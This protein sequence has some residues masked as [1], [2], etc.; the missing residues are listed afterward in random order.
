M[1]ADWFEEWAEGALAA[2]E[3]EQEVEGALRAALVEVA[4]VLAAAAR[5][6]GAGVRRAV[7]D[8]K[9]QRVQKE[10]AVPLRMTS[11]SDGQRRDSQ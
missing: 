6:E 1:P 4:L 10:L 8:G 5:G 7:P 3:L 9:G 11:S 2:Q